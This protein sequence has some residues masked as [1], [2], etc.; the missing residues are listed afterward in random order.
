MMNTLRYQ[1]F[2]A[3]LRYLLISIIPIIYGCT[4]SSSDDTAS[5][6]CTGSGIATASYTINWDPMSDNSNLITGFKVYFGTDSLIT[7]QN[8]I[9]SYS[10]SGTAA[11]NSWLFTPSD[12]GL[13]KCTTYNFAVASL[14]S[15]DESQLS[16]SISILIE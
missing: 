13:Q 8:A 4:G 1:N 11:Q 10:V 9:D 14:G 3:C 7:K 5:L 16:N 2:V 15:L 12:F 6:T